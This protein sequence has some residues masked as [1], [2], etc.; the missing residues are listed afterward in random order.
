[1][2]FVVGNEPLTKTRLTA[3][4]KT[5]LAADAL[6]ISDGNPTYTTFCEA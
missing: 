3:A 4:L 1:M 5:A 6:L 2:D